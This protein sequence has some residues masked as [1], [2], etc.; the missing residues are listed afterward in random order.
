MF[1]TIQETSFCLSVWITHFVGTLFTFDSLGCI[2]DLTSFIMYLLTFFF[3][4]FFFFLLA[5]TVYNKL[6]HTSTQCNTCDGV[7]RVV[8]SWVHSIKSKKLLLYSC[9][10]TLDVIYRM[11][12]DIE[13]QVTIDTIYTICTIPCSSRLVDIGLCVKYSVCLN[14]LSLDWNR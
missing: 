6:Y 3:F 4:F 11:L 8:R 12:S 9:T 1:M 14:W 2:I 13:G 10:L 7:K 5:L